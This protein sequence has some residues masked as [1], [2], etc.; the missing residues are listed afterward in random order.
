MKIMLMLMVSILM[1][2]NILAKNIY[3]YEVNDYIKNYN[4]FK[5]GWIKTITKVK[6][7]PLKSNTSIVILSKNILDYYNTEMSKKNT[8]KKSIINEYTKRKIKINTLLLEITNYIPL[9]KLLLH[10]INYSLFV[11]EGQLSIEK[12]VTKIEDTENL[13]NQ[14]IKIEKDLINTLYKE[15]IYKIVKESK[16]IINQ[17]SFN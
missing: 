12:Y 13:I 15:D 10:E 3:N 9:R 7:K 17:L 1:T 2:S 4:Y 8:T 6:L 5:S 14:L 16:V 11:L